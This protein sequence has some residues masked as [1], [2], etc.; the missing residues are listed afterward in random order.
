[1]ELNKDYATLMLIEILYEW[2]LVDRETLQA[3]QEKRKEISDP[4]KAA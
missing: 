2:G 4:P 1:M 3:A